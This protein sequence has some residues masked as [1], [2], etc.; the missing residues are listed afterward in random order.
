[1]VAVMEIVFIAASM[2]FKMVS[3]VSLALAMA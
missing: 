3:L 2:D 1:M